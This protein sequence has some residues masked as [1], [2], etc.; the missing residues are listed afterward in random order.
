MILFIVIS[1]LSLDQISK[2]IISKCLSLG[3]SIPVVNGIFSLT[4]V[5]NAGAAFGL[6]KNQVYIFILAT[7]FAVILILLD[8]HKKENKK[9]SLYTISLSLVLAGALGNLVDRVFFGYVIDFLD[10]HIW[11]VFNIADSS[12]TIGAILLAFSIFRKGR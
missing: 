3:E 5:H 6:L 4:L 7:V 11:P 1:I 9:V 2:F 10:F 8:L 12:I